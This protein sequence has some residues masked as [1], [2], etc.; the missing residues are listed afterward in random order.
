[1]YWTHT[2]K[3]PTTEDGSV[4]GLRGEYRHFRCDRHKV[5]GYHMTGHANYPCG[6]RGCE[7]PASAYWYRGEQ[8]QRIPVP[9]PVSFTLGE[10]TP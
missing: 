3:V 7:R 5:E 9:E 2:G 6:V 1:M 4:F 8:F 10:W